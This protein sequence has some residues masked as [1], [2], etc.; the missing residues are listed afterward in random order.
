MSNNFLVYAVAPDLE[1][2]GKLWI[3]LI[4]AAIAC[5]PGLI[6]PKLFGRVCR[7]IAVICLVVFPSFIKGIGVNF[8]ETGLLSTVLFLIYGVY[9]AINLPIAERAA[10]LVKDE[11][12]SPLKRGIKWIASAA[13]YTLVIAPLFYAK[14]GN[15]LSAY[16][17]RIEGLILAG[18][19]VMIAALAISI[20]VANLC[21]ALKNKK[22]LLMGGLGEILFW[23]GY[24][25]YAATGIPSIADRV[26]A[27]IIALGMIVLS[28]FEIRGRIKESDSALIYY[29]LNPAR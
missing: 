20:L 4:I 5:I 14:R 12:I 17:G 9:T 10:G 7:G 27:G 28:M 6:N 3:F 22:W 2:A 29:N 11:T 24:Y 1:P 23:I 26:F 13:V 16:D 8:F 25:L 21:I 18:E 15:S 19:I